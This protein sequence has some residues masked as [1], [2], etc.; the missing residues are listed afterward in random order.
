[1]NNLIIKWT[2]TTTGLESFPKMEKQ[3]GSVI[4]EILKKELYIAAL[5]TS[6]IKL[7]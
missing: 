7:V 3:I 4:I 6:K 2:K 5:P 1:M